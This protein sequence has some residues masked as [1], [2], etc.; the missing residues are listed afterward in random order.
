MKRKGAA[1]SVAI[2]ALAAASPVQAETAVTGPSHRLPQIERWIDHSKLPTP[3]GTITVEDRDCFDYGGSSCAWRDSATI[4]LNPDDNR[5]DFMH[6]LG[7]FFDYWEMTDAARRRFLAIE[8]DTR[9]WVSPPN[10]PHEQFAEVYRYL[11]THGKRQAG[12]TTLG[13]RARVREPLG[14]RRLIR[15]VFS[16]QRKL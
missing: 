9:E 8:G 6:E 5:G 2:V 15:S 16:G 4:Y 13:Y 14:L 7:H 3:R 1:V 12:R 11:A 10:S